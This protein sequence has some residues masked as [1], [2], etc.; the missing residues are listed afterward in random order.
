MCI[1]KE[2]GREFQST[3]PQGGR[4]LFESIHTALLCFNPRPRRG[5]DF[6]SQ[7]SYNFEA[8]SIHAPAGGATPAMC[9]FRMMSHKFQST[10]PQGG[11]LCDGAIHDESVCFNPRPRRG[12]DAK[13]AS[14]ARKALT[15][16]STPPQ[17][18]RHFLKKFLCFHNL[19]S[20]HAPAGGATLCSANDKQTTRRFNPRPRRGGDC[21]RAAQ[22]YRSLMFQSTPPQG[23]RQHAM[24]VPTTYFIVSI[25]A[26][27]GGA[28]RGD[29]HT[30]LMSRVSIHAPAGGAT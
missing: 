30:V 22:R 8:V 18:G 13:G 12:G 29:G 10:P 7:F 28:T 14:T 23:G 21:P 4:H 19:V 26:P 24:S 9:P 5:G 6:Y 1:I 2:D 20:I 11:R 16:Q 15:F 17:G 25:H 27:A 3:P